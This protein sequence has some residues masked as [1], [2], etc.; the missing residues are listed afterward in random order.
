M[1][2]TQGQTVKRS[3]SRS[4]AFI[5]TKYQVTA[6]AVLAL[7]L[8]GKSAA[9]ERPLRRTADT[10]AVPV[11][12][13][14]SERRIIVSI[15]D[16]RLALVE[17]GCVMLMFRVAVGAPASPSPVG[18][19]RVV[20]L[21]TDPVY[22]HP[23]QVIPAGPENP[24]GPR[25]IGLSAKGYGIHGTNEPRMIGRR[26]S[27][28]CIRLSNADVKILFAHL[29]VGDVVELHATR[30]AETAQLFG[31]GDGSAHVLVASAAEPKAGAIDPVHATA[32]ASATAQ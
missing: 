20:N 25:W 30:D 8:A 29:R 3:N 18:E 32:T 22:Y 6:L 9:Q 14:A 19:F 21:V 24:V 16:R 4:Q 2:R 17:N 26:A 1:R 11:S 5:Q 7:A 31:D 27:H 28:G 13:V 12:A 15:P 23:G 10:E